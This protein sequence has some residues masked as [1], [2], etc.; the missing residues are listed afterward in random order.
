MLSEAWAVLKETPQDR[1]VR[2]ALDRYDVWL[3]ESIL[4]EMRPSNVLRQFW[5]VGNANVQ[6][7]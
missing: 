5:N 3:A 6:D 1:A 4:R 7:S 2:E